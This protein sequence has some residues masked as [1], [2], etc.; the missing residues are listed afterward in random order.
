M[1]IFTFL[2]Q[3]SFLP[4]VTRDSRLFLFS[5]VLFVL[6]LHEYL[7]FTVTSNLRFR[8]TN[9][10]YVRFSDFIFNKCVRCTLYSMFQSY[11]FTSKR[12]MW[13]LLVFVLFLLIFNDAVQKPESYPPGLIIY[14]GKIIYF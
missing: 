3:T 12:K 2:F 6:Y 8:I 11:Y 5:R 9:T 7:V 13:P 4:S 1:R 14:F 10:Y